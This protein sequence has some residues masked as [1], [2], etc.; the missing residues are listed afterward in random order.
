[1][2]I[3]E[4]SRRRMTM[5]MMTTMTT[6]AIEAKAIVATMEILPVEEENIAEQTLQSFLEIC[7]LKPCMTR[8]R[9]MK[10]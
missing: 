6:M 3:V 4:H 1:M 10:K 5:T 2:M 9:L 7:I 8:M